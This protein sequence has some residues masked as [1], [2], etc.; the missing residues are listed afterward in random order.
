MF[1]LTP[2]GVIHTAISLIAVAAGLIAL[3]RDKEISP[4]NTLG[5]VYV[6]TTV[7]VCVTGFWIFQHGGLGRPHSLGA[8]TLVGRVGAYVAGHTKLYGRAVPAQAAS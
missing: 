1:G 8:I 7:I 4:R 5:K 2:L 3:V 6:I